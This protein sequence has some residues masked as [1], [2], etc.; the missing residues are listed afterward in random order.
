MDRGRQAQAPHPR[1]RAALNRFVTGLVVALG[2]A[3]FMLIA[4]S[5]IGLAFAAAVAGGRTE[6]TAWHMAW[7]AM[8]FAALLAPFVVFHHRDDP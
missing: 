7:P 3:A 2:I 5:L 8:V 4:A 6:W 1:G